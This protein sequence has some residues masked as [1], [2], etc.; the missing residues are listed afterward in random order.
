MCRPFPSAPS[1]L[2]SRAR[3]PRPN[4]LA[5]I[6]ESQTASP[7]ELQQGLDAVGSGTDSPDVRRSSGLQS[8]TNDSSSWA[9]GQHASALPTGVFTPQTLVYILVWYV[10]GALTNSTSKQSL[11]QFEKGRA[12]WMSLTLMQHVCAT[13]AGTFALRVAGLR[14]YKE[15]PASAQ[16]WGFYRMVLVYSLGFCMTNGAFGAV[17]ASFV[18][19]VK[20]GEPLA[21]MLLTVLFLS[22]APPV[23]LP[24]FLSLLPIVGGVSISAMAEASFSWVGFS[25]ALGSN[26]CN[27]ARS[28]CAKMLKTELGRN[29]DN[30]SLFLHVNYYGVLLLLPAVLFFEG[31]ILVSLFRAGGKPARLFCLNGLLYYINNQMNFLVLEKVDAVTH[32][33]INCGRR[34]AN[35]G[36]AIVWFGIPVTMYNGLGIG[37]ALLGAFLYMKAKQMSVPSRATPSART[38]A[39]K[40]Q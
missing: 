30:A 39:S 14:R 6:D 27:A 36:F 26:I 32:G 17:N 9:P 11:Q 8:L 25:L 35:I 7:K 4:S 5:K 3:L 31:P 28:I 34:V 2:S 22:D 37:L 13:A 1:P 38:A 29:M 12:P 23:T 20:A 15:L 21:T 10:T 33:L 24:I 16:T 19:T 40:A 18:D